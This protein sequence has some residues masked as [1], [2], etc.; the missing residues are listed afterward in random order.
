[1]DLLIQITV[2][3]DVRNRK[4]CVATHSQVHTPI[5]QHLAYLFLLK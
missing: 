4:H 3:G 5:I 2:V 1:M